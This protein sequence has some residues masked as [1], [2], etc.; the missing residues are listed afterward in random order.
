MI[1]HDINNPLAYVLANLHILR[2]SAAR[3]WAWRPAEREEV[4]RAAGGRA[5]RARAR[6]RDD[7]PAACGS[8][9]AGTRSRGGRR[10]TCTRCWSPRCAWRATRSATA[11][12]WCGTTRDPLRVEAN[13]GRLGQVFL[14]LLVNAAQ[15]IPEGGVERNEIRVVTRPR[16]TEAVVEIRRHGRRA[17]PPSMLE[18]VFEPFFTTKPGGV[19]TGLGLSICRSIVTVPRR[20]AGAWR[21]RWAAAA[22]SASSCPRRRLR[23]S[24]R[25][26]SRA[27][28]VADAL[29]A[30]THPHRG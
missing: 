5:A 24:C 22:P 15:A 28:A 20:A 1:A 21:A 11:R 25:A 14:N 8:S 2:R 16:G 29:A 6:V 30:G 7:R 3:A 26:A 12:G 17:S 18:R 19:G 9:R 13:E 4:Q 27:G 10:W 23:A